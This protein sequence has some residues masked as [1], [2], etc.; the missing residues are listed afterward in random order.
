MWALAIVVAL[1]AALAAGGNLALRRTGRSIFAAALLA[2][3]VSMAG[4]VA[5]V[6]YFFLTVPDGFFT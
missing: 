1:P 4:F 5:F 3:L 6:V 2:A